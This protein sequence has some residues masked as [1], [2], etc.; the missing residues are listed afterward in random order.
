MKKV[1]E[2]LPYILVIIGGG[3]L[4]VNE[5]VFH[6][7][8]PAT[9]SLA[10]VN[11]VQY[12]GFRTAVKGVSGSEGVHGIH[13][14][15]SRLRGV[16][17]QRRHQTDIHTQLSSEETKRS[18]QNRRLS[19]VHPV[20]RD[21]QRLGDFRNSHRVP[22]GGHYTFSISA[23]SAQMGSVPMRGLAWALLSCP[24]Y[25]QGST[26]TFV[27]VPILTSLPSLVWPRKVRRR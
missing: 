25:P 26:H 24:A 13:V 16:L 14:G 19:G 9:L 27:S 1:L 8:R 11:A 7:G 20:L 17:V 18:R 10:V 22:F 12:A 5:F 4:L 23:V 3:G 15:E 21:G 2:V 6:W